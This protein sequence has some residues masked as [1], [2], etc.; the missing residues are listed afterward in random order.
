MIGMHARTGRRLEGVAH[1]AQ[2]V[3]DILTTMVGT[4]PMH[5]GYGSLLPALIDHPFNAE[6]RVRLYGA[7]AQA[8]HRWEPDLRL[9]RID[10]TRA[11]NAS[12]YLVH[13]DGVRTDTPGR[14][15][16]VRLSI[17]IN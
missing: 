12:S 10:I 14:A 1:L 4:I 3:A 5:R 8:L 2:R 9:Q 11:E 17:P 16:A 7:T 13:I 15:E 6:N